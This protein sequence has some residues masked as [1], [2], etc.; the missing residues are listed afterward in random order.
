MKYYH[1][2]FILLIFQ[3]CNTTTLSEKEANNISN[4]QVEIIIEDGTNQNS[5][6]KINAFLTNGEK[7]IINDN[8]QIQLNGKPLELFVRTGNYYDKY[9]VYRTDELERRESYYFEIILP[10]STKHPI[11]FIKPSKIT[12][13]FNFPTNFSLDKDYTFEWENNNLTGDMEIWKGVHKKDNPNA[14]SGGRY[15]ESTIHHTIKNDSG[16]YSVQ[17]SFYKDSLTVADYLKIRINS[18]ENG[19]INPELMVSSTITFDYLMEKTIWVEK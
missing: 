8:I 3:S 16:N 7:S 11:A 6:N 12:S 13:K 1:I 9:P 10:D 5:L 18:M 4:L 19:L 17:K 2:I 15:A 14:H